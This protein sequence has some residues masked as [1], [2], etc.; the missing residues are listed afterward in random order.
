[1]KKIISTLNAPTPIGPYNQAVMAND[2]F[3]SG[4]IP[5]KSEKH[6]ISSRQILKRKHNRLWKSA[7][8]WMLRD[9]IRK[10]VVKS[11]IFSSLVKILDKLIKYTVVILKINQLLRGN[12]SCKDVT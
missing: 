10:N 3:I 5:L 11:T 7:T 2:T 9:D 1:M 4:Q 6:G 8:F 12:I